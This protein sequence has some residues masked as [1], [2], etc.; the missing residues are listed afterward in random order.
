MS[1]ASSDDI[2]FRY[3][4]DALYIAADRD[5]D[6]VID[7]GAVERALS[8]AS[9]EINTYVGKKYQLPLPSVPSVMIRVCVD[10]AMYRM[11]TG[12]ALTEEK[13]NRFDDAVRYLERVA[14]GRISL[15]YDNGSTATEAVGDAELITSRRR[16][17]RGSMDLLT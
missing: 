9:D 16:F 17:S 6:D 15:G 12:L 13:R 1:Y 4:R 10:I 5:N 7:S 2:V 14:D 3:G 11:S 8:D